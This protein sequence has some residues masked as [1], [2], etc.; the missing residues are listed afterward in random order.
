MW[1]IENPFYVFD[2]LFRRDHSKR[3]NFMCIINEDKWKI[4][5]NTAELLAL[6]GKLFYDYICIL[7]DKQLMF[8]LAENVVGMLSKRH[9]TAVKN[10][11][12]M[13]RE[14]GYNRI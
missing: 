7:K 10:I 5:D 6:L 4:L 8:F 1:G 12:E 14:C 2:Y 9:K 3:F 11:K 13:F